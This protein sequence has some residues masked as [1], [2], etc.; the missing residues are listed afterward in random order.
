[1]SDDLR[2]TLVHL[3][4]P[5]RGTT[6]PLTGRELVAGTATE[7]DV[8]FPAGRAPGVEGRHA[9]LRAVEGDWR[10]EA[11]GG[12]AVFVNGERLDAD[13]LLPGDVIQL[14]SDGPV[15]RYRLEPVGSEY[16]SLRDALA[17][18]VA[19]ARYGADALPARIGLFLRSV[20]EELLT[21]TSP[22]VR[23]A[24]LVGVLLGLAATGYQVVQSQRLGKRLT[25]TQARLAAVTESLRVEGRAATLSPPMLDSLRRTAART[26]EREAAV[27]REG[28]EILAEVSR[29]V[30]L[31]VGSYGF[32]DPATGRPLHVRRVE[33]GSLRPVAP[34]SG[35]EPLLRHYTGTAFAATAEGHFVTNRHLI[36]PWAHDRVAQTLVD[37][38]FRPRL[39]ELRGYVPDR[40]E[41]I[42]LEVLARSDSADL[43]L[44]E[45]AGLERPPAPLPLGREEPRVGEDVY[46]L[47]Y[48]TGIKALLARSD[49]AFVTRLRLDSL[50]GRPWEIAAKL[51]ESGAISPLTTRGIVGQVSPS[52][53]VYDAETSKGGSG[54]PVLGPEGRVVAVNKGLMA[55]FA[56]SNLGVPV[57]NVHRLLEKAAVGR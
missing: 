30:I 18:C 11:G 41:P 44:L 29:S 23:G 40:P 13:R 56:G 3:T 42:D 34:A 53:V 50:R 46:L 47:G 27:R 8:H 25:E 26:A 49:P 52:A 37:A 57:R 43:A 31:I 54:G 6:H 5:R 51:A 55:E 36:R 28:P 1:M 20:P 17:D 48:P 7:A 22:W 24:M 35:G 9:R 14:G 39:H 4:G 19:C 16:K 32:Q 21:R 45:A 12:A 2:P 15:L 33:S 38:G 10:I